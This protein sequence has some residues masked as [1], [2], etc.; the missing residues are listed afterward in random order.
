MKL[1]YTSQIPSH[2][3]RPRTDTELSANAPA[4]LFI[5]HTIER[6]EK[7]GDKRH[8]IVICDQLKVR[9][10]TPRA[11]HEYDVNLS[12]DYDMNI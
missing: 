7:K 5:I 8:E 10:R 6:E 3:T 11:G 1:L 9:E 12:N 4:S 2:N